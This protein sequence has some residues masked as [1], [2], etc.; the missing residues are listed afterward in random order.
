VGWSKEG[1]DFI[2]D[3]MVPKEVLRIRGR[4]PLLEA[5]NRY[6]EEKIILFRKI[7]ELDREQLDLNSEY[8]ISGI[9]DILRF[10]L[11]TYL[12]KMDDPEVPLYILSK[13]NGYQQITG[14]KV[15]YLNF[16]MQFRYN[17]YESFKRYRIV[18]N[19]NGIIE[20]EE[21]L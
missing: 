8:Y 9:N 4:T 2:N 11:S 18:F 7:L 15:Y 14:S 20:I 1:V 5:D 6:T 16:V 12:Q 17:Q 10:N 19:R 3:H 13:E 21:L